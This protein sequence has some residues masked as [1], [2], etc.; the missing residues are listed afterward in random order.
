M[1][2][3]EHIDTKCVSAGQAVLIKRIAS[4]LHCHPNEDIAKV[5]EKINEWIEKSR[6]IFVPDHLEYLRDGGRVSNAAYLGASLLNMKPLIEV[7]DGKLVCEKKFRGSMKHVIRKM[8]EEFMKKYNWEENQFYFVYS[9]GLDDELKKEAE[10][11][12][13]EYN[14]KGIPWLKT[15]AVVSVH[16]GPGTFGICGMTD[17]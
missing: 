10:N 14:L 13:Y 1:E 5:K 4:Y 15:G 3:V 12:A 11:L 2:A 9:E 7:K 17:D 8:M 6:M 16:C